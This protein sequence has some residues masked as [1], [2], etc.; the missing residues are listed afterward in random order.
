[1]RKKKDFEKRE[2]SAKHHSGW[3]QSLKLTVKAIGTAFDINYRNFTYFCI[4]DLNLYY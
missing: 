1:M 3:M 4:G 2:S